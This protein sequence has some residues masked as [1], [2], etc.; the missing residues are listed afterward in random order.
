VWGAGEAI[1]HRRRCYIASLGSLRVHD[2]APPGLVSPPGCPACERKTG[3]VV[4][5]PDLDERSSQ[6]CYESA[7]FCSRFVM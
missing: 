1:E 5:R 6:F 7:K 4:G 3:V 2:E